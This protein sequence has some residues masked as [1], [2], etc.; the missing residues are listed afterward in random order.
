MEC[1]VG[2]KALPE[3][4]IKH[5]ADNDPFGP[6]F[7]DLKAP[8]GFEC[9]TL[10]RPATGDHPCIGKGSWRVKAL[11]HPQHGVCYELL[12]VKGR[13]AIL[14][15]SANWWQQLLGCIS[16]GRAV[17]VVE[18]TWQGKPIKEMGVSSSKD[19]VGA[20]FAHMAGLDFI[21]TIS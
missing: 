12:D 13:T 10:E 11:P 14:I 8:G 21:L 9:V 2:A 5:R 20:F 15:H 6:T 17:M 16:L 18:G 7:G 19:A 4:F 1:E 3:V